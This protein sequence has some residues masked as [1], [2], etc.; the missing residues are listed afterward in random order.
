MD[1]VDPSIKN[2]QTDLFS[3][4]LTAYYSHLSRVVGTQKSKSIF[5][6]HFNAAFSLSALQNNQLFL[7][8]LIQIIQTGKKEINFSNY[9]KTSIECLNRLNTSLTVLCKEFCLEH[10]IACFERISE[11]RQ[12][13]NGMA[14]DYFQGSG[15]FWK[16]SSSELK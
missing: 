11:Y 12:I 16:H 4:S 7:T 10:A 5:E 14:I 2:I 8:Y 3:I 13:W 15:I 6:I 1:Q 9:S